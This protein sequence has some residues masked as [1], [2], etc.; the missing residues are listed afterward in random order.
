MRSLPQLQVCHLWSMLRWDLIERKDI[1]RPLQRLKQ[2][3]RCW[4]ILFLQV[5]NEVSDHRN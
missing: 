3:G 1:H 2:Y 4:L 5:K